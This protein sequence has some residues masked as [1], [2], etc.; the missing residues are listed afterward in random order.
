MICVF[1]IILDS[2]HSK[3]FFDNI[4]N[5]FSFFFCCI[6]S[7]VNTFPSIFKKVSAKKK[8]SATY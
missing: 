7:E 6:Y 8:K 3:E 5:F 2:D 4:E 1:L